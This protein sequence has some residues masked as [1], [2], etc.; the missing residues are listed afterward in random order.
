M[1]GQ[2]KTNSATLRLLISMNYLAHLYLSGKSEK[3]LVGNF[4]GDYVKGN[5]YK[6]YADEIAQGI[7]LHR[8][9]DSFTDKHGK[10]RE[11]KQP[12]RADFRLYSGIVVDVIFDHFL[13]K[14]WHNYSTVSLREFTKWSHAV[15]LAHYQFLPAL[16]QRFLPFLIQSRRLESYASVEGIARVIEIMGKHSSLPS[17]PQA[18]KA[19]LLKNYKSLEE[20][21][22]AFMPDLIQYV[23]HAHRISLDFPITSSVQDT[24]LGQHFEVGFLKK[25]T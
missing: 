6:N 18:V 4:I 10:C 12:F 14:N 23:T 15:L 25:E 16:V 11:A 3:I 13:A 22:E 17:K 2:H 5:Q 19:V 21:F 1:M 24:V 8:Y 9:I 7:L 20:N